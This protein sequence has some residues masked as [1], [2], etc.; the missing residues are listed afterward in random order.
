MT[1]SSTKLCNANK[2]WMISVE[3]WKSKLATQPDSFVIQ[4]YDKIGLVARVNGKAYVQAVAEIIEERN[5]QRQ[6]AKYFKY[7]TEKA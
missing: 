5:I 6:C 7:N 1:T 4:Q 2:L 3:E